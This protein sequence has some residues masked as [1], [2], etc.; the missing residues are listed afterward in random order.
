MVTVP[1]L[2]P[3]REIH[4]SI[5]SKGRSR[6]FIFPMAGSILL[7]LRLPIERRERYNDK[8]HHGVLVPFSYF[9]K[10]SADQKRVYRKSDEIISLLLPDAQSL[11][12]FIMQL[13]SALSGDKQP[14]IEELCRRIA[15]GMTSQLH[16]PQVRVRVLAVRPAGAW[17]ELH[18]LYEAAEGRASAKITLWM[19]TV[20]HKRVVAF[21]SFLRTLLHELCHHADYELIKL[22]DSF[23]TEGF[24]KRESSLFHQLVPTGAGAERN[25]K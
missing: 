13:E 4:Q 3:I 6:W 24:Y 9:K 17:G 7:V 5:H 12:P 20:K 16:I 19:R 23:H 8:H 2:V 22:S 25:Q 15:S 10:L 21:R 18:G 14:L 1:A 11:H